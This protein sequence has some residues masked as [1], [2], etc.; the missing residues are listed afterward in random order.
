MMQMIETTYLHIKFRSKSGE[1]SINL[2]FV[3][4]KCGVCCKLDDFLAAGPVKVTA[5]E[6]PELHHRVEMIYKEMGKR[7]EADAEEYDHYITHT[8][9]PFLEDKVCSIYRN[10]PE[11]CRRFPNTPFG[12]L[13]EDCMALKRFKAQSKALCRGRRA[14]KSFHFTENGVLKSQFTEKQYKKC[15]DQLK[16]A[17][18]TEEELTIFAELNK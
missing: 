5:E 16:K 10:R 17:G 1:W 2:P 15:L 8:A 14:D 11:G 12:M 4:D 7:W 18:V 6:N 3:C 9:C 13:S